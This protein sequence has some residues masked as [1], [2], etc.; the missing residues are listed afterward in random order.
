M[1]VYT[2]ERQ[3]KFDYDFSVELLK[4]GCFF[5]RAKAI[6]LAKEKFESMQ[7]EYEDEMLKYSDKDIYDPDEYDSG[8]LYVEEDDE[9]GYYCISFGAEEHYESHIVWVEEWDVEE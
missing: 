6:A 4:I 5:D 3:N 8:A 9:Y 7:G 2:V 1:K